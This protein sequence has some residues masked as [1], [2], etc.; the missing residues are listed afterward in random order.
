MSRRSDL[1]RLS[2]VSQEELMKESIRDFD[3][4]PVL[5][6]GLLKKPSSSGFDTEKV[7]KYLIES[8]E[9][10]GRYFNNFIQIKSTIMLFFFSALI[11]IMGNL[12]ITVLYS[13]E[14]IIYNPELSFVLF[15]F[16]IILV[17]VA[18]MYSPEYSMDHIIQG[19]YEEFPRNK[20]YESFIDPEKIEDPFMKTYLD[21]D[22]FPNLITKYSIF[23]RACHL[24]DAIVNALKKTKFVKIKKISQRLDHYPFF[25]I[26]FTTNLYAVLGPRNKDEIW[27][28]FMSLNGAVNIGTIGSGVMAF[29]L[30]EGEWKKYGAQFLN[31]ISHL[32]LD[33]ALNQL[34]DEI[35]SACKGPRK[36]SKKNIAGPQ[37]MAILKL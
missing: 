36:K 1:K 35:K 31:E 4:W 25:S 5:P 12:V 34:T 21:P 13:K 11:G 2:S 20:G 29:E 8:N 27:S 32:N 7:T 6:S 15:L 16:I 28:E 23:I 33:E 14:L 30:D 9:R 22:Y 24:K 18:I 19:E 37:E 10:F 3:T 26:S 17:R